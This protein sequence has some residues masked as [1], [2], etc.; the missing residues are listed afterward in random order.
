M[1]GHRLSARAP[2]GARVMLPALAA[3]ACLVGAVQQKDP[4]WWVGLAMS[5][6]LL[7]AA[8]ATR[9]APFACRIEEDGLVDESSGQVIPFDTIEGVYPVNLR[10]W[11]TRPTRYPIA[12]AH[13]QGTFWLPGWRP[14]PSREIE[15]S[16]VAALPLEPDTLPDSDVERYRQRQ[17]QDFGSERVFA[18]ARR[19]LCRMPGNLRQGTIYWG[20]LF[21]CS[22]AALAAGIHLKSSSIDTVAGIGLFVGFLGIT[23]S[24]MGPGGGA[25]RG[26]RAIRSASIVVSPT[27]MAM[28]QH[29]LKGQLRWDEI[30]K[31]VYTGRP[32][33]FALSQ[34]GA[35]RAIV[36]ELDGAT[37][38]IFD[39][40]DRPLA[41]IHKRIVAYWR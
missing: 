6:S 7:A 17:I 14:I 37:I 16:L 32:P 2:F 22:L 1:V 33:R 38:P 34:S 26:R 10:E 11:R 41:W 21:V 23:A 5:V 3:V 35:R 24:L 9:G 27:G 28:S 25:P 31:V 15:E 8:L 12:I 39:V 13:E 30:R 36:L 4:A 29:D 18:F 20:T 19:P 40:Y